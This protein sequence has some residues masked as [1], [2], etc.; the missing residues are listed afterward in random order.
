MPT[1]LAQAS[2][3][4]AVRAAG[5]AT[6]PNRNV[7]PPFAAHQVLRIWIA[8]SLQRRALRGLA[9][10]KRLLNDVGLTREQALREAAKPFWRP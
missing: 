6:I 10:E 4:G 9:G 7:P 2:D 5:E 8:R 3:L 1:L